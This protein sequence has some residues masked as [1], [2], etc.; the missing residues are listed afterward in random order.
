MRLNRREL[1]AGLGSI[2]FLGYGTAT[3]SAK[4]SS[5][6]KTLEKGLELAH[7]LT[8][9]KSPLGDSRITALKINSEYYSL[10]LL[11]ASGEAVAKDDNSNAHH[12]HTAEEWSH[13]DG[14]IAVINAGM[15]EPDGRNVG[16]MK[17]PGHINNGKL[18]KGYNAIFVTDRI[19]EDAPLAQIIDTQDQNYEELLQKY[20]TASQSIRMV[21]SKGQRTWARQ[22]KMWSMAAL[23]MTANGE[24]LFFHSRSPYRVAEFIDECLSL[25]L[26]ARKM[27][28]L[29]GGPEASL[30]INHPRAIFKG[31]GSYETGF[32]ENDSNK[33]FWSLP[34]VFGVKRK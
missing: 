31:I 22:E 23:G 13:N 12:Y 8:K 10:E 17:Q 32:N 1:L 15:F 33:E 11:T 28:Y 9:K 16:Y 29:E 2:S 20:Q 5:S 19:T 21:S 25:P 27:M 34:N 4:I 18:K 6:W 26:N 3:A 7:F 14:L 24:V 30:Y